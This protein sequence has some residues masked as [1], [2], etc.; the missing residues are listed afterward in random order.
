MIRQVGRA[1]VGTGRVTEEDEHE[2]AP[3]V[4][5]RARPA[6]R[7]DKLERAAELDREGVRFRR[8]ARRIGGPRREAQ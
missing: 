3:E 5:V 1:D 6:R 8:S 4:G 7:V 2:T